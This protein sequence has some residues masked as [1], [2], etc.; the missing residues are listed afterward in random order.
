MKD[1]RTEALWTALIIGIFSWTTTWDWGVDFVFIFLLLLL[2]AHAIKG[3][4][5]DK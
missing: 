3:P 4:E 5:D 2:I 1:G